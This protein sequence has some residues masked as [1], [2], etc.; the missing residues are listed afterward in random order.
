MCPGVV[1]VL[2]LKLDSCEIY[3]WSILMTATIYKCPRFYMCTHSPLPHEALHFIFLVVGK[4][5]VTKWLVLSEQIMKEHVSTIF[6]LGA[7]LRGSGMRLLTPTN[8]VRFYSRSFCSGY[9][10]TNRTGSASSA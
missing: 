1:N 6:V 4:L 9:G 5:E 10:W 2:K 3:W 8:L 7:G